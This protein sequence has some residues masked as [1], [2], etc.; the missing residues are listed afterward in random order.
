MKK[1]IIAAIHQPNFLPWL[2]FFDKIVRADIFIFLDHT[3]TRTTTAA[4]TKRVQVICNQSPCWLTVPLKQNIG[5]E[6]LGPINEMRI[7]GEEK[8]RDKHLK[9]IRH[10]Y[11]KSPF[12]DKTLGLLDYFYN[13]E[14]DFIAKKNISFVTK[15]CEH[16]EI[17]RTF[18]KS[19]ELNCKK[20]STEL[21]A[22]I[23]QKVGADT[24]LYGIGAATNYQEN[25]ILEEAGIKPMEQNFVHPVYN[26]FNLPEFIKGLSIIDVLMNCGIEGTKRL[27]NGNI[28]N[29]VAGI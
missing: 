6:G 4:W 7:S 27:I 11:G 16:L 10:N 20:S 15:L 24:Y 3:S 12:Y 29:S 19:S 14:S 9:T 8:Y 28:P 21:M 13:F 5:L 25:E 17:N 23:C 2:G 26:Q 18:I 22:E 1:S